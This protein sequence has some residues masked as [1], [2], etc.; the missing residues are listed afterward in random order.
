M[1]TTVLDIRTL[2]SR[3]RI[4]KEESELSIFKRL[5]EEIDNLEKCFKRNTTI[6]NAIG[7][8][9]LQVISVADQTVQ[10]SNIFNGNLTYLRSTPKF[11]SNVKND[12]SLNLRIEHF[13]Q[14]LSG[15]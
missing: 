3:L 8:K 7:E 5:F 1:D 9:L 15:T 13:C 4:Q 12:L 14:R 11:G 6:K 2:C 10:R